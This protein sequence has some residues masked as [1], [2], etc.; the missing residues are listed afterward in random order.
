MMLVARFL[1]KLLVILGSEKVSPQQIAGGI[2]LG[3]LLGL[4]PS[5]D[6]MI[7][8]VALVGLS[9]NINLSS[10]LASLGLVKPIV[11][12]I[13]P[14]LNRVGELLLVDISALTPVWTFLSKVP[15]LLLAGFNNTLT[16]GALVTGLVIWWPVRWLSVKAVVGYRNTLHPKVSKLKIVKALKIGKI[17]GWIN[18]A[19]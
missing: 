13:D 10:A 14:I 9:L 2:A 16:L 18:R 3:C 1:R 6:L 19:R 15:F 5:H 17:L 11:V 7:V 12:M 4:L 8:I